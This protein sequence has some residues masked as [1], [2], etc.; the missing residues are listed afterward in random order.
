MVPGHDARAGPDYRNIEPCRQAVTDYREAR[1][2]TAEI[3]P[4]DWSAVWWRK[5]VAR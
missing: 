5:P 3:H 2:I 1:A 4:V